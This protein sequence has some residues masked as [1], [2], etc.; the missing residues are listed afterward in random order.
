MSQIR[1]KVGHKDLRQDTHAVWNAFIDLLAKSKYSDLRQSQR[2]AY[3][4]FWYES[5]IQNGGHLQFVLNRGPD[6]IQE[7]VD[8]LHRLG[9]TAHAKLLEQAILLW[10][11]KPRPNPS[12][13]REYVDVALEPDFEDLDNA[14]YSFPVE[15]TTFLQQHLL[16]Y[17]GEFI[18]RENLAK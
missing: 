3:L 15:L 18:I 6:Q 5:E 9:A 4:V 17:E 10:N 12:E 2:P 8:A 11:S 1:R 13:V 14:F 7:T 16:K